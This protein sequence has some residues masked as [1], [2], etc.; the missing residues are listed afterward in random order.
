M[1]T[2]RDDSSLFNL[3]LT[4]SDTYEERSHFL[5]QQL[6]KLQ[7]WAHDNEFILEYIDMLFDH[8]VE[9][10]KFKCD[11]EKLNRDIEREIKHCIDEQI[12]F[13]LLVSNNSA[14]GEIIS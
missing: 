7:H 8:D 12:P 11:H 3:P 5:L 1:V 4:S 13:I 14:S 2:S 9:N 6:K 10:N